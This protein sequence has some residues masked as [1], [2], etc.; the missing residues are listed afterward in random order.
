NHDVSTGHRPRLLLHKNPGRLTARTSPLAAVMSSIP[1][2]RTVV[3]PP[4][5]WLE[6]DPV[7]LVRNRQALRRYDYVNDRPF[8]A[9][10]FLSVAIARLFGSALNGSS[11]ERPEL[12]ATLI[13]LEARLDVVRCRGGEA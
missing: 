5:S 6:V 11:R 7:R 2:F 4:T 10:S 1:R 12:A 13:P 9:S 8:V 3:A